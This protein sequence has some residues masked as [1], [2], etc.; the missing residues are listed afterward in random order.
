MTTIKTPEQYLS[1]YALTHNPKKS[2]TIIRYLAL[3]I[4]LGFILG[5]IGFLALILG[6]SASI[7]KYVFS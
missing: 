6:L 2:N 3:L 7:W 5:L 4:I 1:E